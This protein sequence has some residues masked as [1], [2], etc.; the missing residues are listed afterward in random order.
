MKEYLITFSRTNEAIKGEQILLDKGLSVRVMPLPSRIKA[1][2]GICFR[3]RPSDFEE[4]VSSLQEAGIR[5]IG[6]YEK[7]QQ[8]IKEIEK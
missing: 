2:C 3:I 7:D 4:A 1:G 8:S 5:D 6:L